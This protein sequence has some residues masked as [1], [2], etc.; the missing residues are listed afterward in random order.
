[1][2]SYQL[3]PKD[4]K[5]LVMVGW[6]NPLNTFFINVID[7]VV[8]ENDINRSVFNVGNVYREIEDI[9]TLVNMVDPYAEIPDDIRLS[10]LKD[11]YRE[12]ILGK[13]SDA[14]SALINRNSISELDY[15]FDNDKT[16]LQIVIFSDKSMIRSI[17]P[18]ENLVNLEILYKRGDL[19]MRS[20]GKDHLDTAI[21]KDNFYYFAK[22]IPLVSNLRHISGKSGAVE[23]RFEV[24]K[25][26]YDDTLKLLNDVLFEIKAILI[27]L[28]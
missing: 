25:K 20:S 2:S 1:M 13:L 28:K 5:H 24:D 11:G 19:S 22:E 4:S 8:N 15:I 3:V 18:I 16:S 7:E 14:K 9:D 23:K 21:E 10:L 6:D 26:H 12:I 27:K 17:S